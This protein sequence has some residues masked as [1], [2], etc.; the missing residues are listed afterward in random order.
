MFFVSPEGR[1]EFIVLSTFNINLDGSH[2][3]CG[4]VLE[5]QTG[6]LHYLDVFDFI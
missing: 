3:V 6:L 2:S 5:G 4:P 1:T